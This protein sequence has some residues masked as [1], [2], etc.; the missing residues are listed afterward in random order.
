MG[1]LTGW[2]KNLTHFRMKLDVFM[3]RITGWGSCLSKG[4][5]FVACVAMFI[6][7]RSPAAF[8]LLLSLPGK[9]TWN[10]HW[11]PKPAEAESKKQRYFTQLRWI[12]PQIACSP[13]SPHKSLQGFLLPLSC[14]QQLWRGLSIT[15]TKK[16]LAF[17]IKPS[18]TLVE[19]LCFRST[20]SGN[21][22]CFHQPKLYS[23]K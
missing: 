11:K 14:Q 12:Y 19:I 4:L 10:K 9:A 16:P 20:T 8:P 17:Q 15:M 21:A 5:D 18:P 13:S 2:G 22:L 1:E 23:C 7:L 3:D 6:E